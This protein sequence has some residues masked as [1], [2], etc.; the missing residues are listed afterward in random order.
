[1]ITLKLRIPAPTSDLLVNLIGVFGLIGLAVAVGG[2]THSPWWA[3]LV[4]SVESVAVHVAAVRNSGGADEFEDDE[5]PGV[6]A[7]VRS[8]AV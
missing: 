3:L 6:I 7:A 1:M 8:R 5:E 2:L 4:G